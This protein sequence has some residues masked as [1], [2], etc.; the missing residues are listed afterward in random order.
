[1]ATGLVRQ[2]VPMKS[3][4]SASRWKF[5]GEINGLLC[6]MSPGCKVYGKDPKTNQWYKLT[7][8]AAR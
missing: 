8:K 4:P 3:P 1:M 2:W 7:V 6:W 5:K